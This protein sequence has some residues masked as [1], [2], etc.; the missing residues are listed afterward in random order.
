MIDHNF[1]KK[2]GQNFISDKNL[3]SAIC[4]DAEVDQNTQV[5]EIGAGAGTLTEEI[6]KKAKKVV[7]Y[8]IDKDLQ[9]H[10]LSLN[11]SNT[12]FVFGD[13]MD[14]S[15]EEIEK[16]F[17]GEYKIIANLPYYITTPI[18]F[19][20]LNEAQNLKSLTIMVQK[21]VAERIVANVGGKDYGVLSIMVNFFGSAKINRI[22]SRKMFY[23]QPNVDSAVVT[24]KIDRNKF[25]NIDKNKFYKFIQMVFSMRRKTLKNN[26]LQ[27]GVSEE[28]INQIDSNTLILRSE[29]LAINDL[30]DIYLKIIDCF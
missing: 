26:L 10:L 16:D 18:I 5:L 23:P 30:L 1:K 3:L 13:V 21:E 2:F 19:K 12:K 14:F 9:S 24:I 20:F 27:G 6:S 29:K 17:D 11:L 8:E 4:Q 25:E 7:S 15:T 22:V 28:K